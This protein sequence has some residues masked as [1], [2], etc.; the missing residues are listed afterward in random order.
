MR[1]IQ[2]YIREHM[3]QQTLDALRD[4]HVH[5]VSVFK[6]HGFG[7]ESRHG[8]YLD[9]DTQ[10][11]FSPIVRIEL[12]CPAEDVERLLTI[13]RTGAHTGRPGDG[14][15]AVLPVDRLVEIRTG[16]EGKAIL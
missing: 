13:I 16:Q 7:R 10:L 5:G 2:A 12:L 14:K 3:A 8:E 15:I 11:G 1:L 6:G 9:Q 4:A